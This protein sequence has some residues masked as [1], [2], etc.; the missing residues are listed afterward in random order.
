MSL[1]LRIHLKKNSKIKKK[2]ITIKNEKKLDGFLL[3]F[4]KLTFYLFLFI[5]KKLIKKN[6]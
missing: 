3:N 5:N 4:I 2:I 6:D 1:L